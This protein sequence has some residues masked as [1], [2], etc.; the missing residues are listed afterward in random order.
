M[1]SQGPFQALQVYVYEAVLEHSV[2]K[3]TA[4]RWAKKEKK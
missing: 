1:S 4:N 3:A 2:A